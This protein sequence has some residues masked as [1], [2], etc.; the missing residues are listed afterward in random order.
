[1]STTTDTTCNAN[2]NTRA[3]PKNN[4]DR[5]PEGIITVHTL[6]T[7]DG[8]A[9]E[10]RVPYTT[11]R[12]GTFVCT[13]D[14][15]PDS[16][17]PDSRDSDHSEHAD[18]ADNSDD[19][20]SGRE[21]MRY[22]LV[23][24]NA[25]TMLIHQVRTT[26]NVMKYDSVTGEMITPTLRGRSELIH[27]LIPKK[28]VSLVTTRTLT[29]VMQCHI[30]DEN[31]KQLLITKLPE[32]GL[33]KL[34][35]TDSP[36]MWTIIDT[37]SSTIETIVGSVARWLQYFLQDLRELT[38]GP[39]PKE[40]IP[41]AL[42][43]LV[44]GKTDRLK[45]YIEELSIWHLVGIDYIE[46]AYYNISS[47]YY[48]YMNAHRDIL[49]NLKYMLWYMNGIEGDEE[50]RKLGFNPVNQLYIDIDDFKS[51][52]IEDPLR[53]INASLANLNDIRTNIITVA[54]F[55]EIRAMCFEVI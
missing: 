42:Y 10:R 7:R 54:D 50:A 1:M 5:E 14:D 24:C 28:D 52:G 30:L 31:T 39:I 2:T 41:Q 16:S 44:L 27:M 9:M 15:I 55:E 4:F 40:A 19:E 17:A 33:Q 25:T 26:L 22:I 34:S 36:E 23:T 3:T 45:Q 51:S 49:R 6:F 20:S 38:L 8:Y 12:D 48:S 46:R 11:I 32:F 29:E 37:A 21:S 18:H 43:D 13:R 35:H 47:S 53:V